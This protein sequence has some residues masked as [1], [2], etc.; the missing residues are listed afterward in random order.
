FSPVRRP[1]TCKDGPMLD[2]ARSLTLSSA[3]FYGVR[4]LLGRDGTAQ[5]TAR[6]GP[7]FELRPDSSGNND[8]GVAYEVF[9]HE[10]YNDRN[11]LNKDKIRFVVDLGANVG[12]SLLYFLHKYPNCRILALEPHP[13]HAAQALRNLAID[14]N[15]H[16]VQ[17]YRQAA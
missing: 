5:F 15:L 13:L 9:V 4:R 17:L 1:P 6:S 14:R 8:Y 10:Y 16:R 2:F 11:H 7:R 12:F 3:F